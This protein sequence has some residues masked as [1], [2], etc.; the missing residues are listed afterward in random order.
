LS[1]V[2]ATP[3]KKSDRKARRERASIPQP[4][5]VHFRSEATSPELNQRNARGRK[6]SPRD[7]ERAQDLARRC[8]DWRIVRRLAPLPEASTSRLH[9]RVGR[10]LTPTEYR[11]YADVRRMI[12]AGHGGLV[13]TVAQLAKRHG[14]CE[15]S[16]RN[17]LAGLG[18][19]RRRCNSSSCYGECAACTE[20]R[21]RGACPAGCTRH[22]DLVRT[23]PQFEETPWCEVRWR[24]RADGTLRAELAGTYERRQLASAYTLGCRGRKPGQL[25][26]RGLEARIT[27]RVT[28]NVMNH[29][30]AEASCGQASEQLRALG[31][32]NCRPTSFSSSLQEEEKCGVA[33]AAPDRPQ[34]DASRAAGDRSGSVSPAATGVRPP[35]GG[36]SGGEG[37]AL[38]QGDRSDPDSEAADREGMAELSRGPR[39]LHG[40]VA[41]AWNAWER[42]TGA[43]GQVDL[44]P[45]SRSPGA[46]QRSSRD[47][48][49]PGG[50]A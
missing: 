8:A 15:R 21:L 19:H 36:L 48:S 28:A 43:G 24:K 16:I 7:V 42:E 39:G 6:L 34:A 3:S 2:A 13:A 4:A 20:V 9:R 49:A 1:V 5:D 41:F 50:D 35:D 18:R 11:I 29:D 30:Q 45:E 38:A 44:A 46:A 32:K 22:V 12:R 47:A 25:S 26:A 40:D 23:V 17:A 14:V 27:R 10:R 33:D 37:G 31:G